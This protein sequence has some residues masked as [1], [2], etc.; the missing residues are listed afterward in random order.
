MV[1]L[2][3]D[4]HLDGPS[5]VF[6]A[7]DNYFEHNF[8]EQFLEH[9]KKA[10]IMAHAGDFVSFDCISFLRNNA[11]L[12]VGVEGNNDFGLSLNEYEHFT[13]KG[14][15]FGITHASGSYYDIKER[16]RRLLVKKNE[17]TQ[18]GIYGH[19][20]SPY[21]G[22]IEGTLLVNPGTAC[23]PRTAYGKS[24]ATIE[25][26]TEEEIK[27]YDTIVLDEDI[28]TDTF[29]D[30]INFLYNYYF[31]YKNVLIKFYKIK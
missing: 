20:H 29:K 23:S 8:G 30:D 11:R 4:T 13:Y 17:R 2:L 21:A 10:D 24:Y 25:V 14:V 16:A 31:S 18:I 12:F 22:V 5:S 19:S 15:V 1:L 28:S 3:S 27:A 6:G 9:A 7:V 26:L